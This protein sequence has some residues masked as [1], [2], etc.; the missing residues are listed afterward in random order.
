MIIK[1]I[2]C[3]DVYNLGASLQA[4]ALQTYLESLR[5]DVEII[6]YKPDYLSG[7][8]NLAT[9][10]NPD[11][12]KPLIRHL[13]LLAKLPGRLLAL[14]RK[15][16]FDEF[17]A[18]YLKLT[19][20][21]S[22]YE[23][24]KADAPEADVYIA[25][26]DQ[27]WNTTFRNGTDPAFY[28]D[29]GP[30]DVLRLS[31]A[32]SF[33]TD[34]LVEGTE[35]FVRTKLANFDAISVRESSAVSLLNAFGFQ[36]IQVVDPVFLLSSGQ[37]DEITTPDGEADDYILVYDFMKD[38]GIQSIAMRL[39]CHYSCKIYSIGPVRLSYA[40]KNFW[41]EGP[42]SFISL[43]KHAK[44]VVSNSF[45]GTAFSMI[46]ERDFFVVNRKDGLNMRMRDIL[47]HYGI[48]KRQVVADACDCSLFSHINYDK[49]RSIIQQDIEHSKNWLKQNLSHK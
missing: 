45:H 43:I 21:Y 42:R 9:V 4:Y 11:F 41:K 14:K 37:W 44:C 36:G 5:H 26:S 18:N 48:Q 22:S 15:K 3:H 33:A 16:L 38:S 20:R 28:L 7:H 29:F 27:I 34:S 2:T 31:Y 10:S 24:L 8:F 30:R 19:R 1:T 6:H 12:D 46:Y 17:T 23:E 13:Y 47:T 40:H 32:A 49:I 35:D 39:A 25:G